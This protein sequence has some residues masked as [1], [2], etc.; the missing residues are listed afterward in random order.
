MAR[1]F[2]T[3]PATFAAVLHDSVKQVTLKN[4]RDARQGTCGVCGTKVTVL[5]KGEAE[6]SVPVEPALLEILGTYLDSRR[7]RFPGTARQRGVTAPDDPQKIWALAQ[8]LAA[9]PTFSHGM[10]KRCLHQEWSMGVDEAIEA[11]AQAQAICMMTEDFN[12]ASHSRRRRPYSLVQPL[13]ARRI[14]PS[15]TIAIVAYKQPVTR[16]QVSGIRG[17]N[18]DGVLRALTDRGLIDPATGKTA[19][20]TTSRGAAGATARAA[21][22]ATSRTC[23]R[24][25]CRT[26]RWARWPPARSRPTPSWP[27]RATTRCR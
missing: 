10:T 18:S 5:G 1:G 3:L 26:P 14:R 21:R 11:E 17:V 22:P 25:R 2:G 6:R 27:T 9:G 4:G 7:Q 13:V 23:A 19:D 15:E 24:T 20:P 8:S 16:H 12:R